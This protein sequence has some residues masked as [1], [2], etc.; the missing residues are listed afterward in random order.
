MA[1]FSPILLT[2]PQNQKEVERTHRQLE[3][4]RRLEVSQ[5]DFLKRQVHYS[6]AAFLH[7]APL[8]K[9][10]IEFMI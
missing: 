8:K 9:Y 1:T 2:W 4:G 10:K 5:A 3:R 6:N 7:L